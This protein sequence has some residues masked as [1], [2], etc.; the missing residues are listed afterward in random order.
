MDDTTVV[1]GFLILLDSQCLCGERAQG[2]MV[3]PVV[4]VCDEAK[5][6][7]T[8]RCQTEMKVKD[9][10]EDTA[11]APRVH[12]CVCVRALVCVWVLSV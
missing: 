11:V 2:V 3:L 7:S 8:S 1:I 6:R 10:P 12:A 4:L 5:M 9:Q